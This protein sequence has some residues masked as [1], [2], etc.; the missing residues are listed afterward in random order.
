[1]NSRGANG[2]RFHAQRNLTK[3]AFFAAV[4]TDNVTAAFGSS[5]DVLTAG[6]WAWDY[7]DADNA[8]WTEH[9]EFETALL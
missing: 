7:F 9:G 1:M 5:G 2:A 8:V 6:W 3:D 4:K